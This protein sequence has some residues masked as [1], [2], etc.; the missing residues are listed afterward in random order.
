MNWWTNCGDDPHDPGNSGCLIQTYPMGFMDLPSTCVWKP[1]AI[2]WDFSIFQQSSGGFAFLC[3][4]FELGWFGMVW[5]D[6]MPCH[7]RLLLHVPYETVTATPTL[8]AAGSSYGQVPQFYLVVLLHHHISSSS[9]RKM[10]KNWS[11]QT[12]WFFMIGNP[13]Q[14][15][16]KPLLKKQLHICMYKHIK[17]TSWYL[18]ITKDWGSLKHTLF[19]Q[20]TQDCIKVNYCNNQITKDYRIITI[21]SP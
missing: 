16:T 19:Y 6:F 18:R 10:A 2:A 20:I 8:A 1:I 21:I 3:S 17:R 12:S 14:E 4:F 13:Q 15:K 11:K 5:P 7:L 9:L